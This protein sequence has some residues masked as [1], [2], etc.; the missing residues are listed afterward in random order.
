MKKGIALISLIALIM[1]LFAFRY[2]QPRGTIENYSVR[3]FH[4][5]FPLPN[6]INT[7]FVGSGKCE[8]CHGEGSLG[9]NPDANRDPDGNDISPVTTWQATMMANSAKDPFWQAKLSHEKLVHPEHADAIDAT[10]IRCH[11]PL[12]KFNA[13]HHDIAYPF[14]SLKTD[15]I[16][17]DGVSCLACH[18]MSADGL[19]TVFSSEMTYDTSHLVFGQYS[20]PLVTPMESNIGY[21]PILGTHVSSSEMCGACH[22]L[23]TSPLNEFGEDLDTFF[24]EQ[25][26]Y[27]EWL[28]SEYAG[29]DKTCKGCHM[30]KTEFDVIIANSPPWLTARSNYARHDLV[31]ANVFMLKL[32]SENIDTLN[33]TASTSD[34]ELTIEKTLDMLQ[35]KSMEANVEIA[36][37]DADSI[38]YALSLKNLAGHKLPGGYPSRRLIVEFLVQDPNGDTLFHSGQF[39]PDFSLTHE[40]ATYEPHY[41]IIRQEN[42]V[43]IYEMVMGDNTGEVT[44]LLERAYISLKDNR[45]VPKGFSTANASY[46]TV[47]IVGN[48]GVDPNFN[49]DN[50]GTDKIYYKLPNAAGSA[51]WV[52]TA[53]VF[54]QP[55]PP[56][57]VA[58]MFGYTS[59]EID[60]FKYLY[61][62]ADGTPTL[63][64]QANLNGFS[65]IFNSD[66]TFKVYP[67]PSQG[68]VTIAA[69]DQVKSVTIYSTSGQIVYFKDVVNNQITFNPGNLKGA[70]LVEIKLADDQ[71]YMQRIVF[72]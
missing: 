60:L 69:S 10:C 44:T 40:D 31:G 9:P 63:I 55:V 53:R 35:N 68:E 20:D 32:L 47:R 65:S 29:T 66:I 37:S 12:G 8:F 70:Y 27:H 25:A 30:P 21:T 24:V 43:Q 5:G 50:A 72:Q 28:N 59:A 61:L 52:V 7:L 54:Y 16:G 18:S 19:G 67:N 14:D 48:A 62:G 71:T 49:A 51:N 23:I 2:L 39:N 11:A 13:I 6:E 34:F 58:D 56:K 46:D 17:M 33:L 64:A 38:T 3:T 4:A 41:D 26:I 57:W 42:Q 1:S 22:T 45:L 36:E 15:P